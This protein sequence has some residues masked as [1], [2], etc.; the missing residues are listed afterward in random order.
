MDSLPMVLDIQGL[1]FQNLYENDIIPDTERLIFPD[2]RNPIDRMIVGIYTLEELKQIK[3][4]GTKRIERYA[5][6]VLET[7][8]GDTGGQANA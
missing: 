4:F 1:L 8:N 3:G 5:A 7:I 2:G 6:S